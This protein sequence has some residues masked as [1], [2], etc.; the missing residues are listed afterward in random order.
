MIMYPQLPGWL[1]GC[2]AAAWSHPL[3]SLA[4]LLAG[5][6]LE[7]PKVLPHR[8]GAKTFKFV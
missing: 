6:C 7:S 8:I 1:A 3:C 4:G 5:C 2:L